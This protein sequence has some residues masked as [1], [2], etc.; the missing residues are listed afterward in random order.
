MRLIYTTFRLICQLSTSS[1]IGIIKIILI[2]IMARFFV[3]FCITRV[4]VMKMC[5]DG[6]HK[7]CNGVINT[8]EYPMRVYVGVC[9]KVSLC[10]GVH[11]SSLNGV[12]DD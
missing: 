6:L 4:F 3:V 8:K 11:L 9:G 5:H 1:F 2:D 12:K 7:K 10:F